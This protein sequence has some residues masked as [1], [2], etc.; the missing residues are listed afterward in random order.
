MTIAKYLIKARKKRKLS[1]RAVCRRAK[2][3][4]S[5]LSRIESGH[6]SPREKTLRRLVAAM[7]PPLDAAEMAE[8]MALLTAPLEASPG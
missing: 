4:V 7:D 8:L 1:Q 2:L 3:Q 6:A 5:T